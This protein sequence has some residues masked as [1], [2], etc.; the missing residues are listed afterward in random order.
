MQDT[1]EITA[2]VLAAGLSSR[3]PGFKPLLPLGDGTVVEA[4]VQN[5]RRGGVDDITVV[6]GY[7][8]AEM[9]PELD[10]LEVRYVLNK[11]YRKGMFSSVVAGVKSLSSRTEAFFLLPGD[12]PLVRCHTIRMLCK[13]CH[14]RRAKVIYPVFRRQRGHPPLISAQCCPA[15]M[16]WRRPEGLRSLLALYETQAYEVETADEGILMD[17]D[18][19]ADYAIVAERFRHRDIPTCKECEAILAKLSVPEGVVLHS[20]RVSEVARM[21]AERLN[22]AGLR[23]NVG[24]VVAAGLL[25]DVAKGRAHHERLAARMLNALEYC[26]VAAIV[27]VHRDIEFEEGRTPDEAAVLHL[28][29]KL[30]KG[31]RLVSIDERF[32]GTLEKFTLNG[33]VLPEVKRR[34]VNARAIGSSVERLTGMSLEQALSEDHEKRG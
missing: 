8:A 11:D 7:H 18:S 17:I 20:R 24:L 15:I 30:V 33:E 23:L 10:R 13:A 2:L 28:A 21:L 29:D 12:M 4:T 19:P 14:R 27:A 34:L 31:D 1:K 6:I 26:D 22:Q 5:L 25:H 9:V 32:H 16:S 3:A